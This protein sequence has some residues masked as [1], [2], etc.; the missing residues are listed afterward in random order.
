MENI[1]TMPCDLLVILVLL[2][3]ISRSF[4]TSTMPEIN[5]TVCQTNPNVM[6]WRV[7]DFP[8]PQTDI[9]ADYCG[10]GCRKSR[11]CDPGHILTTNQGKKEHLKQIIL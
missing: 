9:S 6:S 5:V 4:L 2:T 11:I 7:E 1:F 8:N 10:R 3:H